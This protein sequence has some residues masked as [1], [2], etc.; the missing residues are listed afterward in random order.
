MRGINPF[1]GNIPSMGF[2]VMD[3]SSG[4]VN[5]HAPAGADLESRLRRI[6]SMLGI[7]VEVESSSELEEFLFG[8]V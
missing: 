7:E 3:G 5:G 6:E 1:L 4:P 8:G 2:A